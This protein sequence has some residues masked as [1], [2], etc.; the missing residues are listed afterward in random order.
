MGLLEVLTSGKK[1]DRDVVTYYTDLDLKQELYGYLVSLYPALIMVEDMGRWWTEGC[2]RREK[3]LIDAVRFQVKALKKKLKETEKK[4]FC[5]VVENI[6]RMATPKKT[7][8]DIEDVREVV[9]VQ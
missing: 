9:G 1:G 3:P 5:L 7:E 2:L 8:F 6:L 4:N